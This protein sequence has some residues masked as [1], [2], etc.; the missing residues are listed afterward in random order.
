[1]KIFIALLLLVLSIGLH[2]AVAREEGRL[3]VCLNQIVD[4]PALNRTT[5]GIKDV[6]EDYV[7]KN[8]L[9][10]D[11]RIESA[12]GQ[13]TLASQIAHSCALQEPD[14][15]VG[16][17]SIAAQ[18]FIKYL[19]DAS[20]NKL[21]FSS[22]TDPI[23]AQLV[24]TI[25]HPQYHSSGV[26][27]FVPLEPQLR[28]FQEIQPQLKRL[29]FLYNPGEANS[30]AILEN[31][32]KIAPSLN[33]TIVPENIFSSAGIAQA[34]QHLAQHSDAFF[35]SN[36]N[37]A[38][39]GLAQ[40]AHIA[41]SNNIPLYVSDTDAVSIGA[42]AALGPN[43]YTLGQQT[44]RMIIRSFANKQDPGSIP[45]EFPADVELVLNEKV[46]AALGIPLSPQLRERA[47][48]IISE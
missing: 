9:S 40:I 24:Q 32:K 1:M 10:L 14:F 42:I 6:L 33:I 11:L 37:T 7:K 16:V 15:F 44:G 45:V 13:P 22:V 29:G 20:S 30:V 21:I 46:A 18:T 26:S 41:K 23:G 35:I 25:D 38:L 31:L 4:H 27:N 2:N 17:G 34:A 28:M 8:N 3:S 43:Q 48:T 39:S 47:H 5:A 19:K 12:Q 36:D